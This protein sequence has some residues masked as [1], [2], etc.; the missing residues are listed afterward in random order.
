[1]QT[2]RHLFHQAVFVGGCVT[3]AF[4]RLGQCVFCAS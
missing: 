3:G 2:L 1:M 4:Q